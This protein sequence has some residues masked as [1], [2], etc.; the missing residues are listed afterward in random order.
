MDSNRNESPTPNNKINDFTTPK[1]NN[2]K[3]KVDLQRSSSSSDALAGN[4]TY[5]PTLQVTF[6]AEETSLETS[7]RDR[8]GVSSEVCKKCVDW[9]FFFRV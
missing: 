7:S 3:G 1:L 9:L 6:E 2:K 4:T 8:T 5:K